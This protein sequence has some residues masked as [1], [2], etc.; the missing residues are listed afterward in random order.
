M[1]VGKALW[2]LM[3]WCRNQDT[4]WCQELCLPEQQA[5]LGKAGLGA[6]K[7]RDCGSASAQRLGTRNTRLTSE[8]VPAA[9]P[10]ATGVR[11][12]S[13]STPLP[14]CCCL[15]KLLDSTTQ[16]LT[17]FPFRPTLGRRRSQSRRPTPKRAR[18]A[19]GSRRRRRAAPQAPSAPPAAPPASAG[20]PARQKQEALRNPWFSDRQPP[21]LRHRVAS[22]AST[23]KAVCRAARTTNELVPQPCSCSRSE[24]LL[25]V[26]QLWPRH[27]WPLPQVCN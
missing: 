24:A 20:T 4:G 11:P 21:P 26:L 12:G 14:A 2:R 5:L 16:S 25:S 3:K 22:P 1:S 7:L 23:L 18:A 8:A 9:L 6:L 10:A 17:T 13:C 19:T 15:G 27:L